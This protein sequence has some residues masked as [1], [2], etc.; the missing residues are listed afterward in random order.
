M[1]D[2]KQLTVKLALQ[3]S[4]YTQQIKSINTSNKQLKSEFEALNSTSKD[5]QNTLEGKA[6]KIKWSVQL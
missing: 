1:S 6:A 2:T 4:S 3:S 5:Y